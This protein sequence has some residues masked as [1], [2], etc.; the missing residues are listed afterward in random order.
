[1][2]AKRAK[3]EEY[4]G[5]AMG[6]ERRSCVRAARRTEERAPGSIVAVDGKHHEKEENRNWVFQA[7]SVEKV[8]TSRLQHDDLGLTRMH[9]RH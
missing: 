1:M 9:I 3:A 5:A 6:C 7:N 4:C 2:D 8:S